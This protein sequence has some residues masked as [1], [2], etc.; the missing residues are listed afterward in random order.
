MNAEEAAWVTLRR[1]SLEDISKAGLKE[2][3]RLS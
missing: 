3:Q 2:A 1:S